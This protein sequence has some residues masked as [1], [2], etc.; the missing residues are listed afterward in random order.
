[1]KL[2]KQDKVSSFM[3]DASANLS[4]IGVFQIVEEAVTELMGKMNIDSIT[5]KKEYDAFWVYTKNRVRFQKSIPWNHEYTVNCFISKITRVTLYFD[6]EIKNK[7]GELCAYSRVEMCALDV[8][9]GKIRKVY[10]VGVND[11]MCTETPT[12]DIVFTRLNAENLPEVEQ[13]KVK[14]T[15]IDCLGHTNNK[16]YLRFI[17]NTYSVSEL[18][19]NPIREMEVVYCNQSYENDVLT[20]H[21]EVLQDKEIF[22]VQKEDK[23]IVKCEIVRSILE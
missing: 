1:M 9:S 6:V 5:A 7:A 14:Y 8:N 16:E 4:V 15:N 19:E 17:L 13:V 20:V 22:A 11:D 23:P 2:T 12:T 21:K 18:R 10:T 3:A